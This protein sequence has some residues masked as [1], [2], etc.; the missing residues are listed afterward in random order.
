VAYRFKIRKKIRELFSLAGNLMDY[1]FNFM[2]SCEKK[3][4]FNNEK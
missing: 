1:F 2:F 4:L 3:H